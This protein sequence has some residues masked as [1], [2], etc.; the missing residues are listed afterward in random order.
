MQIR[1]SL[2]GMSIRHEGREIAHHVRSYVRADVVVDPDHARAL[3]ESREARTRLA[4]GDVT[5]D[6]PD[7]SRYDALLGVRL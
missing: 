3:L 1:V 5:V 4:D 2:A 7:L 6:I